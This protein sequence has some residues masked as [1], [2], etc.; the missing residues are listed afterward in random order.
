M[1][2]LQTFVLLI[3]LHASSRPQYRSCRSPGG[4]ALPGNLLVFPECLPV[5]VSTFGL[6]GQYLPFP[7]PGVEE[8]SMWDL[9]EEESMST[10]PHAHS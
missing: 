9:K 6:N 5:Y 7:A 8:R 2:T 10:G 1:K 3:W 4:L